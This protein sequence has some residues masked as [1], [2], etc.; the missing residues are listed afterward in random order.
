[1]INTTTLK[2]LAF[3]TAIAA[4]FM[5]V[6]GTFSEVS[7]QRDPFKK[8][9]WA[10]K[11]TPGTGGPAKTGGTGGGGAVKAPVNYGPPDI[12]S[13][14]EYFKRMREAAATNGTPM[15]KVT[16]VLTLN[17]MAVTGIFKTPRGYAAMVEA[18]PI[19]LSYTIYPGEKFF[20]GQ[21]VA[22]EENRLVFRRVSKVGEGK[23]VATVENK[24][25]MKYSTKAQ[26]EGTAP[27]QPA[28]RPVQTAS[29]STPAAAATTTTTPTTPSDDP[30]AKPVTTN[31]V[32]PL[33]EMNNLPAGTDKKKPAKG[34]KKTVKVAKN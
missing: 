6:S 12:E 29:N 30:A 23:F 25:L 22:V 7:A 34:G 9:G 26:V 33:D 17:E 19:K 31:F 20:D 32:S 24:P 5:L 27:A 10:T 18:T 11:K 21:L 1:M 3:T 16:S 14:I 8:A 4:A 15:P 13:R 28:E 2:R